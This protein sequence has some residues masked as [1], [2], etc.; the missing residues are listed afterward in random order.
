MKNLIFLF[1]L[2]AVCMPFNLIA[3]PQST[4]LKPI[5]GLVVTTSSANKSTPL[6]FASVYWLSSKSGTTTDEKGKFKLERSAPD[7]NQLVISFL[8]FKS[9][10]V[11]VAPDIRD[12]TVH[13]KPQEENLD[14]V[15]IKARQD[16]T[17]ISGLKAIKTEVITESGLRK[18]A[19]CNLSESFENSATVD[20]G[21]A[22]AVSGARQIQ[23]LGLAGSY[24]QLMLENMPFIRGVA[25]PF[26]L[27]YVPGTW[28]QSI[29]VSKGTSSVING[30]ES[31]TGQINIE[32]KKPEH[33]E[34]RL[35]VN[36][37]GNNEARMEAN[38]HAKTSI[39]PRLSTLLL[40]HASTQQSAIDHNND[41]FMDSPK[42]SQINLLNRWTYEFESHGHAQFGI[43]LLNEDRKGGSLDWENTN[44]WYDQGLYGLSLKTQRYQGWGKIGFYLDDHGHN[45][46]GMQFSGTYHKQ[47]GFY[48][49]KNYEAVQKSAYGNI[50]MQGEITESHRYNAGISYQYDEY[51]EQTT[52][53]SSNR[54]ESVPGVFGQYTFEPT[55]KITAIAGVRADFNSLFGTFVTPRFHFRWQFLERTTLRASAGKGFRTASVIS[56][57]TGYLASSR[58]FVILENLQAEEAWNYGVNLTREFRLAEERKATVTLDFYRTDFVNQVIADPDQDAQKIVF[59][60]LQGT[61]Y[62]NSLQAEVTVEPFK[63]FSTT[64]AFRINDVKI[65]ENNQLVEKAFVSKYKGLLTLSYTTR[66]DKWSFDV[67]SQFNG[68]QRLPSTQTNPAEYQRPDYSPDYVVLHAQITRR[69]KHFEVYAGSE[70]LTGYTQ[71]HPIIAANDP[72]GKYFDSSLIW[73]PLLGRMFYAGLRLTVL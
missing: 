47:S 34:E 11:Y 65:T 38:I 14:G 9:D 35:F 5:R 53:L 55:E 56:E 50:I 72:Y 61:S 10:T 4:P 31:I 18:L 64:A 73:G 7:G 49:L 54:S 29:Q 60:N 70:N 41:G 23:M 26:G 52:G 39:T 21:Y 28:M 42:T 43:G 59:Y 51:D 67:T 27:A 6:P 57:N 20:V 36:L 71:H 16:A 68:S 8:G 13:L 40:A 30:Y 1:R 32:Y 22:D 69:F 2:M 12:L 45:N 19:C 66:F 63:G 62:S 46:I 24:S 15:E 25:A 44:R 33:I 37:Y 58:Q 17:F 3:Q 48:G